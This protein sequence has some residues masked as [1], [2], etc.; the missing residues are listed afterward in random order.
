MPVPVL[1]LHL[2]RRFRRSPYNA[3]WTASGGVAESGVLLHTFDE[4][5]AAEPW[6]PA[7]PAGAQPYQYE[8][9]KQSAS[10]IYNGQRGSNEQIPHFNGEGAGLIMRPSATRIFCGFG[11]DAGGKGACV[12]RSPTCIPGCQHDGQPVWCDPSTV[13][14]SANQAGTCLDRPWQ[15]GPD[16]GVLFQRAAGNGQYNEIII[17]ALFWDEHLPDSVEA[18]YY[19]SEL[20]S[21]KVQAVQLTHQSWLRRYPQLDAAANPLLV[22]DRSNWD[23]PFRTH[24]VN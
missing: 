1:V 13:H 14:L 4:R 12:L 7:R 3:D 10:L 18:M 17:D 6:R 15:P 8:H 19:T 11:G 2:N 21:A 16:L 22:L 23:A 5:E 20:S 9:L 24:A